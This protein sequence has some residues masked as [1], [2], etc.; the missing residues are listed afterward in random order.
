MQANLKDDPHFI[1]RFE[2][3]AQL[4]ASLHHP[5]IIQI[6]DFQI[7]SSEEEGTIVYM[8]TD[9]V[10]GETLA[11][12]IRR[13]SGLGN[14]TCR[15]EIVQLFTSLGLAVDYARQ[16]GMLHRGLKTANLM[17]DTQK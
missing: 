12:Y 4:I 14:V 1:T 6:H 11:D 16:K 13:T 8:V 9:Y 5:N 17:L 7:A 2:R 10:E 3:E 15:T